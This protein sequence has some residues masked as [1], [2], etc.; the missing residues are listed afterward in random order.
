MPKAHFH[1]ITATHNR[2]DL[3]PRC[4]RSVQD[5]NYP[6]FTQ[7][8][9][10]DGSIDGTKEY[11]VELAAKA[12]IR[13][14]RFE[15]NCGVNAARNQALEMMPKTENDWVII[16]DDDDA[17]CRGALESLDLS[18]GEVGS[19]YNW[20]VAPCV[21]YNGDAIG[22]FERYGKLDYVD[23]YMINKRMP[24]DVL[25]CIRLSSIGD[26]K[27]PI[28]IR[29]TEE[30][31]FFGQLSHSEPMYAVKPPCMHKEYLPGGIS[32]SDVNRAQ[33]QSLALRK[34]QLL[35]NRLTPSQERRIRLQPIIDC[36]LFRVVKAVASGHFGP[37]DRFF[38]CRASVSL[39]WKRLKA[40]F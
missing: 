28:D 33:A 1:I 15:S 27:F 7:Y 19:D 11:G 3:L 20:I 6:W 2:L 31:I 16:V 21:G 26:L 5:Q 36:G 18:I 9:I 38:L 13:L 40:A 24:G 12:N 29:Q 4:I 14:H 34:I 37:S 25:H 17:L 10:D 39:L 23:D 35:R 22:K 32:L 8:V 30:W